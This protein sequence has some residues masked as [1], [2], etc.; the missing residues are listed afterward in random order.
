MT[1]Y[2]LSEIL[3]SIEVDVTQFRLCLDRIKYLVG[4]ANFVA[5]DAEFSGLGAAATC[6][7]IADLEERYKVLRNVATDYSLVSLGLSIFE[8][9]NELSSIEKSEYCI[10][11]FNLLLNRRDDYRVTPRSLSFL[12]E[13]GLEIKDQ[14]LRGIPYVPCGGKVGIRGETDRHF[15]VRLQTSIE[16][17]ICF[18]SAFFCFHL[19]RITLDCHDV[20]LAF[21]RTCYH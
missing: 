1:L 12:I 6:T 17:S 4:R 5:I 15:Y 19:M 14:L 8:K 21:E 13:N 9:D 11:N 16:V 3:P 20:F 10:S 2:P 7:R 18:D